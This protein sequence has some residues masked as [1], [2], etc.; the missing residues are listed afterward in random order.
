MFRNF[1]QSGEPLKDA[2][3]QNILNYVDNN[4]RVN[5]A[6]QPRDIQ[7]KMMEKIT[8]KNKPTD[9]RESMTGLWEKNLLSDAYFSKENIQIL[10]NGLRAGVYKLSKEKFIIPPQNIDNLKVIMRSIF[11]QHVQYDMTDITSE[12]KRLN[13]LVLQYCVPAVYGECVGYT[14]YIQDLR[15]LVVPLDLPQHHDRNYKQLELK[16]WF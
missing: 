16:N 15:T 4:G 1:I 13:D 10:Q 5:V 2:Y 14:N 6:D 12:I 8:L 7:F 11:I 9:Y 3:N